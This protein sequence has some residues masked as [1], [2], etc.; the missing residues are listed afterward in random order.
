MATKSISTE[1]RNSIIRQVCDI[2][3]MPSVVANELGLK[4]DTVRFIARQFRTCGKREAK[5]RGGAAT[6]LKITQN[7]GRFLCE[8]VDND[9]TL[10][11][12]EL[13]DKSAATFQVCS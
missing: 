6:S 2:G 4:P 1:L 10:T 11:L 12:E 9:C 7:I 3:K 5:Q 13:K 8:L